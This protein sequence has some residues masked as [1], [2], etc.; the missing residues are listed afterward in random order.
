[1]IITKIET[2]HVAEFANILFVRVHTDTGY[3]GL[4]ETYYTPQTTR[5][6]MH[7]VGAP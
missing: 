2:I 5:A 1:M 3:T 4:G 6:F 7:E